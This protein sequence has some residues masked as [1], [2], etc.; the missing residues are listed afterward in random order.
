M[1]N[2]IGF[3]QYI[4]YLINQEFRRKNWRIFAQHQME[5]DRKWIEMF[6]KN[7]RKE[8]RERKN[9]KIPITKK[10]KFINED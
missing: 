6:I 3:E 9:K 2:D 7:W 4:N 10:Q 1:Y 5:N 8:V